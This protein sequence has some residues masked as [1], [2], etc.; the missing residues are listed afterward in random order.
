VIE[1]GIF[2]ARSEARFW[3]MLANGGELDGVRILSEGLA[4]TLNVPR[5]RS[6]EPDP[7]MF[8]IALP[9]SIGGFWLGGRNT[10]VC[11]ARSPRAICHPGQGGSIGWADLDLNLGVAICHNKLFNASSPEEDPMLPIANA[12]RESLG[13]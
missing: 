13:V 9:I 8:N 1:Q 6:E 11:S 3:G 5:A 10:P 2:N 4:R 7:V 12:V